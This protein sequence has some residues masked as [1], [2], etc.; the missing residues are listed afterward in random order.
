VFAVTLSL[1]ESCDAY[2]N[3]FSWNGRKVVRAAAGPA[4]VIASYRNMAGVCAGTS[5]SGNVYCCLAI[6][7]PGLKKES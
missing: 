6:K 2:R 4:Q 7:K 3:W 5:F 1:S